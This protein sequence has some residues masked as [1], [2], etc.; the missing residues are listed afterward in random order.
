M[1]A[2]PVFSLVFISQSCGVFPSCDISTVTVLIRGSR[3]L[4][5]CYVALLFGNLFAQQKNMYQTISMRCTWLRRGVG[6]GGA[7]FWFAVFD[8]CKCRPLVEDHRVAK[9]RPRRRLVV[10]S[11]NTQWVSSRDCWED[12]NAS[13]DV[14]MNGMIGVSS[15]VQ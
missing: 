6:R 4:P 3:K 14:K 15:L 1:C 8:L 11:S 13:Q 2:G 12:P 7:S 10:T 9:R 5:C